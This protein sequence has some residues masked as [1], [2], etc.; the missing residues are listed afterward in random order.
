[1]ND[2]CFMIHFI[3]EC[4]R[5]GFLYYIPFKFKINW[6]V[7][8]FVLECTDDLFTLFTHDDYF[9]Y[10]LKLL[11]TVRVLHKSTLCHGE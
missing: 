7:Y 3:H 2:S 4:I 11:L 5:T 9:E 8:L 10:I 1:M 6:Y